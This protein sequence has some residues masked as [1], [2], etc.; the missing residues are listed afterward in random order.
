M[1]M[2]TLPTAHFSPQAIKHIEKFGRGYS[3]EVL[4]AK[5][6]FGTKAT[7]R[8]KYKDSGYSRIGN[9]FSNRFNDFSYKEPQ[10]ERGF[11][12]SIPQLLKIM[13]KDEF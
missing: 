3:F 4:R 1:H 10:L 11:G 7:Q 2:A 8:P 13:E 6:L 5:V 9:A 12:I